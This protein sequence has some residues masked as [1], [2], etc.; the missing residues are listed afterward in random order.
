MFQIFMKVF[1]SV[2][3]FHEGILDFH[4]GI[5]GFFPCST[6]STPGRTCHADVSRA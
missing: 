5:P 3:D 6:S 4:E 1:C 2:P